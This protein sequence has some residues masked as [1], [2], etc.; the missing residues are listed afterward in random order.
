MFDYL[1][2]VESKCGY[3]RKASNFAF[4][5]GSKAIISFVLSITLY[6]HLAFM[7]N[8]ASL[9]SKL[10]VKI[11]Q[12]D[13]PK[14]I[15]A[16]NDFAIRLDFVSFSFPRRWTFCTANIL[17]CHYLVTKRWGIVRCKHIFGL[18]FFRI[19]SD[20]VLWFTKNIATSS[21]I[22]LSTDVHNFFLDYG[23][24]KK[25]MADAHISAPKVWLSLQALF[26]GFCSFVF[27]SILIRKN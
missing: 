15:L 26:T 3:D 9:Q 5:F 11:F 18:F 24:W 16:Y 27:C 12:H 6:F 22:I 14:S 25:T 4:C 1:R 17:G 13:A 19:W 2:I 7:W 20:I 10:E 23:R 8:T 21:L